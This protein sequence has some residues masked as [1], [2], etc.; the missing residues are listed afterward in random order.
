M[1]PSRQ[2][3]FVWGPWEGPSATHHQE[4]ALPLKLTVI[5]S[6]P[7]GYQAAI[8]AAQL[9]AEVTVVEA[10]GLGG[11]CLHWGCIPTKTLL[12]S[13]QA[14]ENA[15]RA[16]EFGIRIEGPITPDL[17]AIMARK[18]QVVGL[19]AQGIE[20][21]MRAYGVALL[22]GRGR[23]LAPGRVAVELA[24]GGVRELDSDRVILATGSSPADLPGL[25]RDG[26]GV[27]NSDD[28]LG[29]RVLPGSLCVV[30]GGVVGCEL[31]M[32]LAALG[33]RV[34]IVEAMERL[35]PLPSLDPEISKLLLREM[36]KR[37][38]A[39]HTGRVVT[40]L[41]E[42]PLGLRLTLGP[43]PLLAGAAGPP[44]EIAAEKVLLG[45]GRT[46]N[47]RGLG[48]AE[49][50]VELDR[51]G[52]VRVNQYLE[53]CAPG[54]YALGDLLGSGRPMLAHMA[55]AEAPVAAANALG[56]RETVAYEVVPAAVFTTPEV[57]WVGLSPI[58]ARG[59]GLMA[60]S[61]VFPFRL[62]GK[63]QAMGEIAGECRLVHETG[64]GRLLGA[65]LIGA[66]A[67]DLI[68]ELALCLRLGGGL[69]DLAHTIHP[70]PTLSEALRECAEAARGRCLH[71]PPAKA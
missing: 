55:G 32:I 66:H 43:S 38:I 68:H 62:L 26:L 60:Q 15:R 30:G 61:A 47:S 46:L 33:C 37:R 50:G 11:T 13:A 51:R 59:R 31:A 34:T 14:L 36:K 9:G 45:V 16:S 44:L 53:T 17:E 70:H 10:A 24:Q 6:G 40:D 7:G 35:L 71:L 12:A 64:S 18:D 2:D 65:H 25:A 5:G 21:L 41:V 29:L 42:G 69:A 39:V 52:A 20:K 49:A 54:V 19:Q 22:R 3:A 48:L 56:G 63:S 23:L 58:E 4:S 27:L 28:I 67:S 8:R 1:D 57:A